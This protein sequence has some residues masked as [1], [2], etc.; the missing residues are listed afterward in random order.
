MGETKEHKLNKLLKKLSEIARK[1]PIPAVGSGDSSIG[2][3][4]LKALEIDYSSAIK[5]NYQG[6]EITARR[7][8]HSG[9]ANRVNLF[10]QVPDWNLSACK[11][12]REIL[13][14]YGYINSFGE[15][16]LH[17]TVRSN[18][19]NSQGL[20]LEVDEGAGLLRECV[21]LAR[22]DEPVAVWQL[23]KLQTRLE[24][25]HPETVWVKANTIKKDG[26]EFFHF[27]ECTY[28]GHPAVG[29]LPILLDAG[30]VTVDHLI[31]SINGRVVEK[32]PL[33]KILPDNLDTLFPRQRKFDLLSL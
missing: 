9:R 32:G 16:Q 12:S 6:I 2:M 10:A 33:F 15:K 24:E 31:K 7:H 17:C 25:T 20:I 30:T 14:R 4:L 18:H 11:S 28:S 13:E 19:S 29:V 27:R 3:T 26:K 5:P 22:N 1:G 21:K 23:E 8:S